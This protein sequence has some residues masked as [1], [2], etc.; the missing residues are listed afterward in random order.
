MQPGKDIYAIG[1]ATLISSL[2]NLGLLDEIR[3][4]ALFKDVQGRHALKLLRAEPLK[5][6][7]VGL[8]YS[9]HSV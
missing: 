8:I 2:M 3:L 6:G 7:K 1:G 4:I 5:S 9:T